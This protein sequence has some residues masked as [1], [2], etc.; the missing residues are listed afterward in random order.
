MRLGRVRYQS[1]YLAIQHFHR[2]KNWDISWMCRV[3]GISRASFYK[4]LHREIPE[5]ELENQKIAEL[6]LEYDD[7]F[8]HIL[9]YRRMTSWINR[10]NGTNYSRKRIHRLM[11]ELNVHSVIRRRKKR[12][13]PAKPDQVAENVLQRDFNATKPNEKWATDVTEFK[14]PGD[15]NKKLFLSAIVDLYDRTPVAY[16]VSR[17]NNNQLVFKTYD[18][19]IAENPNATPLF[20]SDRGFQYTSQVFKNKLELQHIVQ[21]MSR[22]GHCIDNGPTEGFWG[23]IKT[24]MFCM[25]DIHDERSLRNAID[26]YFDFYTN[27]RP[28]ER[29][30]GKTPAEVRAEAFAS[31]EPTQY[32]IAVNKRIQKYK[33]K[34]IA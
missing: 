15:P 4:W 24:E 14:I 21:S 8:G 12:Y 13:Y 1:K 9:G 17:R 3:L 18:K 32:P 19:A 2:E 29:F 33:Q 27:E 23:I 20:H 26:K 7:R 22:V 5:A 10:F 6:I 16:V 28:Q 11:K 34:W 30:K 25:Y 31:S